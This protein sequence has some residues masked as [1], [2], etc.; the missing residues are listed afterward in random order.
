M[1]PTT[2]NNG[3][4]INQIS[5]SCKLCEFKTSNK[6]NYNVHLLTPKHLGLKETH[7]KGKKGQQ[8]NNPPIFECKVCNY[9]CTT[10]F[11][12]E[13]HLST[14]KH[15]KKANGNKIIEKKVYPCACGKTYK[16]AS[17]LWKHSHSC[18]PLVPAVSS[19]FVN[20][21]NDDI[22]LRL[23]QENRELTKLIIEQTK[24]TAEIIAKKR[25]TINTD[26]D[27]NTHTTTTNT[28]TNTTQNNINV[29]I[30]FVLNDKCYDAKQLIEFLTSNN[31]NGML[32]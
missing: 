31:E 6:Y 30:Q 29:N 15:E 11:N 27:N 16:H 21:T 7:E 2:N 28:T 1:K 19:Q 26:P 12:L 3:V 13:R 23:V 4:E 25:D 24:K 10:N 32:M 18:K 8:S 20:P 17:S 5:Y 22:I 9:I 14:Q